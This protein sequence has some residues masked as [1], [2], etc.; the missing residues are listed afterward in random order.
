MS[1]RSGA[2]NWI[3]AQQHDRISYL[4]IM[5]PEIKLSEW[6]EQKGADKMGCCSTEEQRRRLEGRPFLLLL[7][8]YCRTHANDAWLAS[9][10]NIDSV[11]SL[12]SNPIA[13]CRIRPTNSYPRSRRRPS[14]CTVFRTM[15]GLI[16]GSKLFFVPSQ[17]AISFDNSKATKTT[18]QEQL[19]SLVVVVMAVPSYLWQ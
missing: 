16:N 17:W 10:F 11:L 12:S 6:G 8:F 19:P 14:L 18:N 1:K 4:N 13:I 3:T 9:L 2:S 5:W 7:L 15:K